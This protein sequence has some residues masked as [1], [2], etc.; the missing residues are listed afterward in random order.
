[1]LIIFFYSLASISFSPFNQELRWWSIDI[2]VNFNM[3]KC[4][5]MKKDFIKIFDLSSLIYF[6]A[7]IYLFIIERSSFF[8]RFLHENNLDELLFIK[9]SSK[10]IFYLKD[11]H[12]AVILLKIDLGIKYQLVGDNSTVKTGKSVQTIQSVR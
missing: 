4:S 11:K 5:N 10:S 7:I 3:S 12:L 9:I 2:A 6:H 1:M 8:L